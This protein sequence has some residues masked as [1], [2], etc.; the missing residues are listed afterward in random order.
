[1]SFSNRGKYIDLLCYMWEYGDAGCYLPRVTAERLLGRRFIAYIADDPTSPLACDDM[2]GEA[3]I[4][5]DRL[6]EEAQKHKSRS[7]A[8]RRSAKIGWKKRKGDANA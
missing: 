8:A 1:M 2:N 6:L 7:E 3:H 5:S 4:F